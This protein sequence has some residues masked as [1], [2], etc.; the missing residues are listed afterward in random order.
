MISKVTITSKPHFLMRPA[1]HSTS[2]LGALYKLRVPRLLRNG[3]STQW[4][5]RNTSQPTQLSESLGKS[6]SACSLSFE[7]FVF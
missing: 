1:H 4:T 6:S 7:K 3:P 5:L 2:H